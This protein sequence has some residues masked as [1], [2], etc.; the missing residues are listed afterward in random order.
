MASNNRYNEVRGSRL[1]KLALAHMQGRGPSS[2]QK[3]VRRTAIES[4][5]LPR[6]LPGRIGINEMNV[7]RAR[8]PCNL[9]KYFRVFWNGYY[10]VGRGRANASTKG[11]KC[12][13]GK[14]LSKRKSVGPPEERRIVTYLVASVLL[15]AILEKATARKEGFQVEKSFD[16]VFL[17]FRT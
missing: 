6:C 3:R 12:R 8:V 15:M 7:F 9:V 14:G 17:R 11:S 5:S 4:K 16:V 1:K 2:N 13:I 10:R